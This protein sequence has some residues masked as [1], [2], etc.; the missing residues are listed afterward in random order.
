[1]KKIKTIL[2][3]M[4]SVVTISLAACSDDDKETLITESE[5][6]AASNTFVKNYFP[7][8]KVTRVEK[9]KDKGKIEYDVYLA[10]GFEITFNEAG[11]WIDV[12]APYGATIPAGIAPVS[13]VSYVESYYPN[14]GINEISRYPSGYSVEL[15]NDVDLL[16]DAQGNFIRIDR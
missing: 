14:E 1:M 5:L 4:L 13:I 3:M 12:D 15:T 6:P 9:D 2:I 7:N 16:F 10:N 11:E 8:V